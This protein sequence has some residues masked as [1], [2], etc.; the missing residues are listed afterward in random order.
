MS[1]GVGVRPSLSVVVITK[2]EEVD[3][4]GFLENF[5]SIGDEIVII[6]DGSTDATEEIARAEGEQVRFVRSPRSASEGFCDQ[7]QKGVS[8]ARGE[9]LLQVDCDMRLTPAL[10]AEIREAIA[11][12]HLNAFSF[13][14]EQYF[15]NRPVR[16]GGFQYWN[17][18]WLSR[19]L[20]T[21]W[22]ER[23]HERIHVDGGIT[24]VGQLRNRMIHLNDRDFD[25]RLEKNSTYS[26]LEADRLLSA[27]RKIGLVPMLSHAVWRA[28]RAYVLML[29]FLDG[30]VGLLWALY[31]FSG[32][33]TPYFIAWS[34][35][36]GGSRTENE[37]R[38]RALFA[39][40]TKSL[41]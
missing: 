12:T 24:S 3:L 36:H 17:Q 37:K 32:N 33:L 29:G 15:M 30:K 4:P 11:S 1:G 6:D 40:S 13:R 39:S 31:Q 27:S 22:S 41:R 25:E 8:A 14:L 5:A 7:R 2:N 38:I 34:A 35:V 21:S 19:R 20:A 18:P 23:V 10:A 28:F 26:R 16:F 9:W